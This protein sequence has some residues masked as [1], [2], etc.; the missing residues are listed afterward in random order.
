MASAIS[1]SWVSLAPR[2]WVLSIASTEI[3]GRVAR[4]PGR[5]AFSRRTPWLRGPLERSADDL[6]GRPLG[7]GAGRRRAGPDELG[8]GRATAVARRQ[9][10]RVARRARPPGWP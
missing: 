7:G 10:G 9:P 8:S 3:P 2:T 6:T 1:V 4:L 5:P